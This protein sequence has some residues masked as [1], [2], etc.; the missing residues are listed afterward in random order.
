VTFWLSPLVERY[1]L[2][3]KIVCREIAEDEAKGP[4]SQQAS[5]HSLKP[6]AR[7]DLYP[8]ARK[9][10]PP[11]DRGGSLSRRQLPRRRARR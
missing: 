7:R 9:Y 10:E 5:V 1:A 2:D 8:R 4:E 3:G 6:G 11:S